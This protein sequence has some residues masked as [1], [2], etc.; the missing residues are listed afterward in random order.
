MARHRAR[1]GCVVPATNSAVEAEWR[2][3]DRRDV[4]LH[5]SRVP[6]TATIAGLRDFR[7]HAARAAALLTAEG[8]CDLVAVCCTMASLLGEPGAEKRLADDLGGEVGVPVVSTGEAVL[9]ALAALGARR[10]AVGTPYTR[11]I[12]AAERTA[13]EGNGLEVL[14]LV[15]LH[16]DLDPAA[17]T[18]RLIAEVDAP[19]VRALARSADHPAAEALLLSCTNLYTVEL[20]PAL[21][22]EL[23]KPVLSSNAATYWYALR[24]LG[25]T[26]AL[27][28]LGRLGACRATDLPVGGLGGGR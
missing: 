20:L 12:D 1:I 4:T 28:A 9:A 27:P 17:L 19:R 23:G 8:M 26:E 18:N 16:A 5:A 21:E 25:V 24:R 6:F 10:V 7:E 3:L 2:G 13:L 14:R 22:A 11:P 15:S